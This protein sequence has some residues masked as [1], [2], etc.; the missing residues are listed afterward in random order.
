[1]FSSVMVCVYAVLSGVV[2]IVLMKI[3]LF[4]G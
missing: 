3:G 1:M 4:L 2:A